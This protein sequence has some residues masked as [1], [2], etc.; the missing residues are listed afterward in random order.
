MW[1]QVGVQDGGPRQRPPILT[2]YQSTPE[3]VGH[4]LCRGAGSFPSKEGG[5]VSLIWLSAH[6]R[7]ISD[8]RRR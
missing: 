1:S 4:F 6:A 2:L 8:F 3:V 7:N 5:H